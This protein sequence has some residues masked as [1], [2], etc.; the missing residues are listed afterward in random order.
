VILIEK[1]ELKKDFFFV[2]S[3]KVA[4]IIFGFIQIIIIPRLLNPT[5]MGL[6]SFWL[7]VLLIISTIIDFGGP[8]ILTRYIPELKIKCQF[9]IRE[10][11]IKNIKIKIIFIPF[12]LFS[13]LYLFRHEKF[14]FIL[15]F[16][17]SIFASMSNLMQA[18]FYGFKDF[19]RYS[20]IQ[21]LRILIRLIFVILLF[22]L[23]GSIGIIYA[24]LGGAALTAVIFFP[25]I[26]KLIPPHHEKLPKSFIEYFSYGLYLYPG[27]LLGILN[28]WL[29]VIL[30]EYYI[31]DME[32]VGYVGLAIQ[33]C[34]FAI[35][36]VLGSVYESIFPS[37]IELHTNDHSQLQ[38]LI[39]L[40]WKYTNLILM[41]TVVGFYFL[42]DPT[43][44]FF[45]GIDY[46]PAVEI[47]K[48]VLPAVV[49]FTWKGVYQQVLLIYE[50]KKEYLF[51]QLGGF[52]CFIIS[53]VLLINEIGV[54]GA[55]IAIS[56]GSLISFL[57]CYI[58]IK[59]LVNITSF[60][61]YTIKPFLASF[62]VINV[63]NLLISIDNIFILLLSIII[64]SFIYL[65]IMI[66]IK[67]ITLDEIK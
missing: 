44:K 47:I 57:L 39:G 35:T 55:P 51:V 4:I 36:G 20:M 25:K 7:S 59:K 27:N 13:G 58:F 3:S 65:S 64:Y 21:A 54:L 1:K 46:L 62:I 56:F 34:L 28:T 43:I 50:R 38:K 63:I 5:N 26:S 31:N 18:G 53:A 19:N 10:L 9:S 40:N 37:L 23:L 41:P 67:E 49:F 60:L 42:V 6:Y 2:L 8:E 66:I 32:I 15:I 16:F 45:I 61:H 11:I 14:Y 33:I 17:A 52:I 48:Y 12:L 24:L 30:V 29:V 22:K